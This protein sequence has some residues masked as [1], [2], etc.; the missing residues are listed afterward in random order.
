[1]VQAKQGHE[2]GGEG[3]SELGIAIGA[4]GN[5]VDQLSETD[6]ALGIGRAGGLHKEL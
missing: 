6:Q 1:M 5:E 3:G 2:I 4:V